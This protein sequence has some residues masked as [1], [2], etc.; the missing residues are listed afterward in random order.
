LRGSTATTSRPPRADAFARKPLA[1]K[2][3]PSCAPSASQCRQLARNS[4][5]KRRRQLRGRFQGSA[6]TLLAPTR[7]M[8][9][10]LIGAIAFLFGFWL[11]IELL[12]PIG[13]R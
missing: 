8:P 2:R 12:L 3:Q 1:D 9:R 11:A 4:V 7:G 10:D 13:A 5:C 6:R